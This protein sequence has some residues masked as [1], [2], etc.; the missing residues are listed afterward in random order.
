MI[1]A[2]KIQM[3]SSAD[4]PTA[5]QQPSSSLAKPRL[6]AVIVNTNQE[7]NP[8]LDYIKNVPWEYGETDADYQVGKTTGVIFL[9]FVAVSITSIGANGI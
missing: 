8:V 1:L 7:G 2:H 4:T 5:I 3:S 6:R 9:R